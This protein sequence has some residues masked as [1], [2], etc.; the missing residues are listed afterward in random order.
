MKSLRP[1][2]QDPVGAADVATAARG[3]WAW[4][5]A[6]W[7]SPEPRPQWVNP[8][9]WEREVQAGDHPVVS[10]VNGAV[11]DG[12]GSPAWRQSDGGK[13]RALLAAV[14]GA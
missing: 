1:R 12:L 2:A 7:R 6:G 3:P 14:S 5:C 9:R 11:T 10:G 8:Y 13:P 4:I